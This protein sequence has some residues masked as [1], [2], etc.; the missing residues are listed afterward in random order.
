[1]LGLFCSSILVSYSVCFPFFLL[2]FIPHS[3]PHKSCLR[4]HHGKHATGV[5]LEGRHSEPT[6]TKQD[7]KIKRQQ[8]KCLDS[9]K[10]DVTDINQSI[11]SRVIKLKLLF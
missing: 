9:E 1:M 4:L 6:A 11:A 7:V 5:K 2:L 3:G 10:G 8:A